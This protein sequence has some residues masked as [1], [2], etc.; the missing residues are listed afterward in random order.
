MLNNKIEEQDIQLLNDILERNYY[1][2][3]K[4]G[5]EK[6]LS[7]SIY[8]NNLY[9]NSIYV[10]EEVIINS[11]ENITNNLNYLLDWYINNQFKC[12]IYIEDCELWIND[13]IKDI[14]FNIL[15]N[16]FKNY[17]NLQ[18]IYCSINLSNLAYLNTTFLQA[19]IDQ[20]KNIGIDLIFTFTDDLIHEKNY[21]EIFNL[22]NKYNYFFKLEINLKNLS[23]LK[24]IYLYCKNH[25]SNFQTQLILFEKESEEW[26]EEKI[27]QYLNFLKFYIEDLL[28]IYGKEEFFK[29]LISQHQYN[30]FNIISLSDKGILNN[31]K[32][33]GN[34][35]MYK[36]L[37]IIVNNLTISICKKIQYEELIIGYFNIENEKLS[38]CKPNNISAL[39]IPAHLRRN[40][41]PQ[42]EYCSFIGICPGFCHGDAYY[43]TLNPLIP[44]R[45]TCMLRLSKYN[46]IFYILLALQIFDTDI[47]FDVYDK[48]ITNNEY[49]IKYFINI[50][51]LIK[52]NYLK[53][54]VL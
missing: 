34:C 4:Q 51:E 41:T 15:M 31:S 7:L 39:M 6:G 5:I 17:S 36:N 2:Y 35:K 48:N 54:G 33:S 27:N 44:L 49:F 30:I 16:K 8:N 38:Q 13:E 45:E 43:K 12:N 28:S 9:N 14:I 3:F 29:L 19:Q 1:F 10:P 23:C 52:D 37:H 25:L 32:C 46:F 21:T 22:C 53:E 42:C 11:I 20:F 18:T 26:I 47:F 50:L 40:M 24:E